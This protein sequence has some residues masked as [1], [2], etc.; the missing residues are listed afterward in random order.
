MR[1]AYAWVQERVTLVFICWVLLFAAR[2]IICYTLHFIILS[3]ET[4]SITDRLPRI[5]NYGGSVN[6]RIVTPCKHILQRHLTNCP[7]NV[8][9]TRIIIMWVVNILMSTMSSILEKPNSHYGNVILGTI[10]FQITNLTI[11]YSTVYLRTDQRKHQSSA[12]LAFVQG[13]HQGPVN[14]THKWPVTRKMFPFD[15]V[16][17]SVEVLAI[18]L[19]TLQVSMGRV[20]WDNWYTMI[21]NF[22][23]L[24]TANNDC[25]LL[26]SGIRKCFQQ[27]N[28]N[29]LFY[30]V[31]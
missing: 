8:K 19:W 25:N 26:S 11:V 27:I 22:I 17:M 23:I 7:Q 13:I 6:R 20:K 9:H 30:Q 5:I 2:H 4:K 28:R 21:P 10:A 15:D 16:I 1:S 14:S 24:V 12:S 31:W 3:M 18:F 29:C